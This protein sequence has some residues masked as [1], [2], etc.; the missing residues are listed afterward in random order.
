MCEVT[1]LETWSV[2]CK[3]KKNETSS[4]A[5]DL[6]V[7]RVGSIIFISILNDTW[8]LQIIDLVQENEH[9]YEM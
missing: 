9:V 2:K 7:M 3:K 8:L 5:S 1:R 6:C 4:K